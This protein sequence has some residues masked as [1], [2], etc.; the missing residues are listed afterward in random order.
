[1]TSD[2]RAQMLRLFPLLM[3][4]AVLMSALVAGALYWVFASL[5]VAILAFAG[6]IVSDYAT[7]KHILNRLARRKNPDQEE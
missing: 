2:P 6:L 1:M 3:G 7:L 5:W 4:G